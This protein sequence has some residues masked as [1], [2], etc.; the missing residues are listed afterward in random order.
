MGKGLNEHT[1]G[2]VR[3]YFP[4]GKKFS[5]ITDEKIQKVEDILNKRP[6][7]ELKYRTALERFG[8]LSKKSYIC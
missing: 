5:E 4:K 1:N 2:L 8:H 7:K 3:Q 6:R